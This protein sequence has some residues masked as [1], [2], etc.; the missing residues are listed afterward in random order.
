[1]FD[2]R[3]I[4]LIGCLPANRIQTLSWLSSS[5]VKKKIKL[6]FFFCLKHL[7]F[8]CLKRLQIFFWSVLIFFLERLDFLPI[9][10]P[11]K[12]QCKLKAT[13]VKKFRK[14]LLG[15]LSSPT[16]TSQQDSTSSD[17][18][19]DS[20]DD[21]ADRSA[22]ATAKFGFFKSFPRVGWNVWEHPPGYEMARTRRG[23]LHSSVAE[24]T[25]AAMVIWWSQTCFHTSWTW[26]GFKI[27]H[28]S[29]TS[30]GMNSE[31]FMNL[32]WGTEKIPKVVA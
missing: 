25:K 29:L 21:D 10:R 11:S 3:L 23:F 30:I 4:N 6:I 31:R 1:M 16:S 12:T 20:D 7:D 2:Y 17:L 14:A 24:M 19:D 18:P 5:P 22:I 13:M 9:A 32:N 26:A 28:S 27:C 15:E 8:F